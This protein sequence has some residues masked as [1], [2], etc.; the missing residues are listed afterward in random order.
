VSTGPDEPV[1]PETTSDE[2]DVGWG[3]EAS[4]LD[5]DPDDLD[6]F[7]QDVPPHHGD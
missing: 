4:T 6:R 1:L 3:D 5:S 7:L 2:S